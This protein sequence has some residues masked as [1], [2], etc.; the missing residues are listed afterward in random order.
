MQ[1]VWPLRPC[2]L[3]AKPM[4][5]RKWRGHWRHYSVDTGSDLEDEGYMSDSDFN[6]NSNGHSRMLDKDQFNQLRVILYPSS[7]DPVIKAMNEANSVQEVFDLVERC[8][9]HL[10]A[11]QASQAVVTLWDLQ[12]VYGRFGFD[13]DSIPG[14]MLSQFLE[15]I[16]SHPVF[17][18][19]ITSLDRLCEDLNS[20][21]VSCMLLYLN[22]MGVK[23]NLSLIH[24]LEEISIMG[25]STFSMSTLSRL[26]V[27]L[28]DSGIRGYYLQSKVLPV[29]VDR[30]T[31][32][33][34][35]EDFHLLTICLFSS[36]S[37]LTE[38]IVDQYIEIVERKLHENIFE[39]C[40]PKI[41]LKVIKLL[42]VAEWSPKRKF[43]CRQLMLCL[44]E[45]IH[46][47][48]I[49]QVWDLASSYQSYLEPRQVLQKIKQYALNVIEDSHSAIGRPHLLCL[50]PYTSPKLKN[51]FETLVAEHLDR[52]DIHELIVILFKTLRYIKTSN[53]KL[54]NAFWLKS[55]NA[56]ELEIQKQPVHFL[57]L[58][59]MMRRNVY[60][61][62]MYFNNNLGG[63]YRNYPF[64][65]TMS[66][67]LLE[68]ICTTT[69]RVPSKLAYMTS[70][71][72]SY[73]CRDGLPEDIIERVLLCGPQFSI[74]DSLVLSRGI[75]ITLA[76]NS[77]LKRTK[78]QQI[79]ALCRMLDSC[80]EQHLKVI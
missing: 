72:L 16:V 52:K 36:R 43:L 54:C 19:L 8:G 70:F 63:T 27:Y 80:C 76:L 3:C 32:C 61:R 12:K 23:R 55:M 25:L 78:M 11:E 75:E 59:D 69:G 5:S 39:D 67:L 74:F 6:V 50:A 41:T 22:K 79:T 64:E 71:L 31:S 21:A 24:K 44:V 60:Q 18:K 17:R 34:T 40:D 10:T 77:S 9:D 15:N 28:R 51:Y 7:G 26:C 37:L 62:Y 13:R 48:S 4:M 33:S 56:V 29:V 14:S 30:I 49:A 20:S 46:T 65:N 58:K 68:D 38:S 53:F 47:L 66:E 35:V 57:G 2:V 42:T 73:S 45:K 1:G